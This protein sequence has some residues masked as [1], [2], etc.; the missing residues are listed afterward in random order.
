MKG[1]NNRA[2]LSELFH[3]SSAQFDLPQIAI[4]SSG[5]KSLE[6]YLAS[7]IIIVGTQ[8]QADLK[9]LVS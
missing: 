8:N 4:R 3:R 9:F 7:V 6:L 1:P 2:I 5:P